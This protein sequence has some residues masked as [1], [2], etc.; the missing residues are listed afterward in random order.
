MYFT[1]KIRIPLIL[2]ES[3]CQSN[4]MTMLRWM[5]KSVFLDEKLDFSSI[6]GKEQKYRD[7]IR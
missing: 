7:E 3:V 4:H 2:L 6:F 5:I 1:G